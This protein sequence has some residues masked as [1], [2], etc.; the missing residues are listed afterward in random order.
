M[1]GIVIMGSRTPVI[2]NTVN[3]KRWLFNFTKHM[4]CKYSN[5]ISDVKKYRSIYRKMISALSA[6][7]L[8]NKNI[9]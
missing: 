4:K 2:G 8:R 1:F 3:V 9:K 7:T 5:M 6:C